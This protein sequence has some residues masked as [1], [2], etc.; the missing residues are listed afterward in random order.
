MNNEGIVALD[1]DEVEA[2]SGGCHWWEIFCDSRPPWVDKDPP[3][4]ESAV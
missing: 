2:V 4:V 1:I 3:S